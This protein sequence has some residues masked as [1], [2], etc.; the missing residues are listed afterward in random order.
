MTEEGF[1]VEDKEEDEE[2]E[3]DVEIEVECETLLENALQDAGCQCRYSCFE[4]VKQIFSK[5]RQ[6]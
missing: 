2:L 4:V 1:G 6:D 3:T 5:I